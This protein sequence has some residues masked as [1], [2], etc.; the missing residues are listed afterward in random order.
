METK[1]AAKEKLETTRA[2]AKVEKQEAV[3]KEKL[4]AAG[5]EDLKTELAD[6]VKTYLPI[7]QRGKL[8]KT[9]ANVKTIKQ[10]GSALERVENIQKGNIGKIIGGAAKR[11]SNMI[12]DELGKPMSDRDDMI[13]I[14][15]RMIEL[16]PSNALIKMADRIPGLKQSLEFYKPKLKMDTPETRPIHVGMVADMRTRSYVFTI[17]H[18]AV[19]NTKK[20]L[21]D[22]FG[23]NVVHAKEKADVLYIGPNEEYLQESTLLD[24]CNNPDRYILSNEQQVAVNMLSD[25]FE[26]GRQFINN[27]FIENKN[28]KIGKFAV[29]NGG[30]FL[31]NVDISEDALAILGSEHTAGM[32]GRAKERFYQTSLERSKHD[33]AI[34]RTFVPQMNVEALIDDM[35]SFYASRAARETFNKAVGGKTKLDI[36]KINNPLLYDDMVSFVD[37]LNNL[38]KSLETEN[39][40]D[41]DIIREF[42]GSPLESENMNQLLA[43]LS[44]AV[45]DKINVDIANLKKRWD[46]SNP[47]PFVLDKEYTYRYFLPEQLELLKYAKEISNNPVLKVMDITRRISFSADGSPITIQGSIAYLA[48]FVNSVKAMSGEV[49]GIM[50]SRNP[51]YPFTQDAVMQTI[52]N[53]PEGTLR[54]ATLEGI[55]LGQTYSEFELS[56]L[57]RIPGFDKIDGINDAMFSWLRLRKYHLW[58]AKSNEL[59]K[60]GVPQLDAEITAHAITNS[61]FPMADRTLEGQSQARAKLLR[62]LPTSYSFMMEP[63]KLMAEATQGYIKVITGQKLTPKENMSVRVMTTMAASTMFICAISAAFEAQRKGEDQLEA[64]WDAI[65]PNPNNGKFLSLI[66]GNIRISLGGPY[67][68]IFRALYPSKVEGISYPVPFAGI[69]DFFKNRM[70]PALRTQYDLTVNKDYS[71]RQILEGGLLENFMRLLFYEVEG[72]SPLTIGQVIED[73][74]TDKEYRLLEDILSGLAG[75][76]AFDMDDSYFKRMINELGNPD[77]DGKSGDIKD[78]QWLFG[79]IAKYATGE[80]YK[81]D[82]ITQSVIDTKAIKEEYESYLNK[83]LY[84]LNT[85]SDKGDTYEDYYT[86]GKITRRQYELIKQYNDLDIVADKDQFLIDHP[87]I[88]INPKEEYLRS[89]PDE[90]A[91]LAL[92]GQENVLTKK[93]YDKVMSMAQELDIPDNALVG[94]PPK[95]VAEPYFDYQD[96]LKDYSS[97]SSEALLFRLENEEFE[98]WGETEYKWTKPNN[99]INVLRINVKYREEDAA[100]N[101]FEKTAN[102]TTQ[103]KIEQEAYLIENP[104]YAEARIQRAGYKLNIPEEWIDTYVAYIESGYTKGTIQGD[105]WLFAHKDFYTAVRDIMGWGPLN[106]TGSGSSSYGSLPGMTWRR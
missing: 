75:V 56:F 17:S 30:A 29:K 24:I 61:I 62:T 63:A 106:T 84:Q 25:L 81:P 71:N 42:L 3:F 9:V 19:V 59:V 99:N 94:L 52:A 72:I 67:R 88:N 101:D 33:E 83:N 97:G 80:L 79:K 55:P 10:F 100:Y 74:R 76:N 1:V 5:I 65:N 21:V 37:K 43:D 16:N 15:K 6:I 48:D 78:T 20:S 34:G 104:N 102:S 64:A 39:V 86:Q 26:S 69:F 45:K 60:S 87:E 31:P 4:K 68:G 92:W 57:K 46:A 70:N 103:L 28:H 77:P 23:R 8:L 53:D 82:P 40:A 18:K 105:R 13:K 27:G 32:V 11:I 89:H 85:D 14:S 22:A 38:Q 47:K 95:N 54:F 49:K 91:K 7:E 50:N 66:I 12:T 36:V 90:N 35:F 41:A 58:K 98:K 44:S 51:L 2:E 96:L 73:F 93:A